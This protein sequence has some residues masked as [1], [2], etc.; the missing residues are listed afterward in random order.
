[1]LHVM[2]EHP[3]HVLYLQERILRHRFKEEFKAAARRQLAAQRRLASADIALD[4]DKDASG[5]VICSTI[6]YAA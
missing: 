2:A 5:L 3:S 1:M 4:N 6:A